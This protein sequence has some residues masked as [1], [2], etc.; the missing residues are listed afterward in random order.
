[1]RGFSRAGGDTDMNPTRERL[2]GRSASDGFTIAELLFAVAILFIV[3]MGVL[4]AVQFAAGSTR[5]AS[6]RQGAIELAN[7]KIEFARNIP[8]QALGIKHSDGTFGDPAGVFPDSESVT[9]TTGVYTVS[10]QVWWLRKSDPNPAART[11]MYKQIKITVSWTKPNPASVSVE[12]AIYGIDTNEVVGDVQI[13]AFDAESNAALSG[14]SVMIDPI[15][16]ANRTVTTGADGNALFGQVPY[17]ALSNMT[18]TKSGFM[19]DYYT[20]GSKTVSPNIVNTWSIPMQVPKSAVIHVQG[21]YGG[22]ISGASVT[23]VNQD[24]R[25]GSYGPFLTDASGNTA[26]IPNLWDTSGPGYK[27]TATYNSNSA[28]STF[29]I[30]KTDA[31]PKNATVTINDQAQVTIT[32]KDNKTGLVLPGATVGMTG[33]V[34][35][36]D[37]G[38]TTK[39]DGT[40]SFTVTRSGTYTIT[41]SKA[42]YAT[43]ITTFYVDLNN[44]SN[45][46]AINLVPTVT[47][48]ITVTDNY[49]GSALGAGKSVTVKDSSNNVDGSGTTDSNGQIV[50]NISTSDTYKVY[51]TDPNGIF[52]S[53]TSSGIAINMSSN[54]T[55][56]APMIAGRIKVQVYKTGTTLTS[57]P[58][59][60]GIA[61]WKA[62]GSSALWSGTTDSNGQYVSPA[63]V[64]GVN[65]YVIVTYHNG[66]F[67]SKSPSSA[68][69][70][71]PTGSSTPVLIT[72]TGAN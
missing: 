35:P 24:P 32:V 29:T 28:S 43:Q 8:Y 66:V 38:S 12:S 70:A 30:V 7:Q 69:V 21:K 57:P 60:L 22:A 16:G 58:T 11:V 45:P 37:D 5:Q 61:L 46:P 2:A 31:M 10:Y 40:K 13:Y 55:W 25:G 64:A 20:F 62:G 9:T 19:A 18:A 17:G 71:V 14:V 59:G 52:Q 51:V 1:M 63:L 36:A 44:P 65:Y 27:A 67:S 15:T 50:V 72:V 23:L 4:G 34:D 42:G 3:L 47:L 49:D 68:G 53:Y 26:A 6:V 56:T 48:T 54:V 39:S 33:P 41:A